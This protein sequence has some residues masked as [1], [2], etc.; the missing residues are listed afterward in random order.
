[1]APVASEPPQ[2]A[3]RHTLPS[4]VSVSVSVS[5][6]PA[7]SSLQDRVCRPVSYLTT[8]ELGVNLGFGW[9]I[10]G[11]SW[12]LWKVLTEIEVQGRV[13]VCVNARTHSLLMLCLW[14][15]YD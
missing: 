9:V 14:C 7:L 10:G 4:R 12:G 2:P 13:F 15:V 8:P 6:L 3:Y 11:V 1:M 5:V